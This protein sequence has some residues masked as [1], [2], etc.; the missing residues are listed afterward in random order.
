MTAEM[1]FPESAWNEIR[2]G[3]Y[4]P[5]LDYG[6]SEWGRDVLDPWVAANSPVVVAL[7]QA[8]EAEMAAV[9]LGQEDRWALYALSRVVELLILP[10]Q[11]P[12]TGPDAP[13]DWLPPSAYGQFVTAI[14]GTFPE[15]EA[16]HPFLHEIVEVTP[17]DDAQEAPLLVGQW[18]PGC[19]VGSLLLVRGGVSVRAGAHHL[20]PVL[21]ATSTLYWAWRRRYR[22]VADLS[23]GWG[24]NS[25]WRTEFRRDYR[26]PDRFVYNA[27][28]ALD[29]TPPHSGGPPPNTDVDLLRYR[30]STLVDHG[31]DQWVWGSHHTEPFVT[32]PAVPG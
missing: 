26:L 25:Q 17:A 24:G 21:A 7:R 28:A 5:T 31:D 13:T 11:P 18:W 16:F 1:V 4:E 3:L 12:A 29:A 15:G 19:L 27:D 6:G 2:F 32:T 8:G 10:S 9:S 23:H 30:C 20:D 22:Q 14:G